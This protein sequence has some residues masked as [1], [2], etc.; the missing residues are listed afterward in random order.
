MPDKRFDGKVYHLVFHARHKA[1]AQVMARRVRKGG[2]LA[3]VVKEREVWCVY[4][5]G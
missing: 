3:R 4:T 2:K 1:D 5:R